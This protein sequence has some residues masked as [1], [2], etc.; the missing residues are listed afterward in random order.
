MTAYTIFDDGEYKIAAEADTSGN[1]HFR[2]TDTPDRHW[3][4]CEVRDSGEVII[5]YN[6]VGTVLT[7]PDQFSDELD[8]AIS[9][10]ASMEGYIKDARRVHAETR[11]VSL[12]VE[13]MQTG[14]AFEENPGETRRLLARVSDAVANGKLTG[15]LLDSNGNTV[16]TY[17]QTT[18]SGLDRD[19]A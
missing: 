9:D 7:D 2:M 18:T 16:G 13:I 17:R 4:W 15:N 10:K 8:L 14:A 12:T 5:R 1:L 3:V 11:P 19:L 6:A